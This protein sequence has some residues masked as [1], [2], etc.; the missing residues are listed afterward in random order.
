[1]SKR[2]ALLLTVFAALVLVPLVASAQMAPEPPTYTYVSEW[3]MPRPQW[4]DWIDSNEKNNKPIYEKMMADG[5]IIGYGLYATAVHDESGITHGSWFET[6]SLAA[7][8]KVMSEI[9]KLPPNPIANAATKH[10]DYLI[11][12]SL[13]RVKAASGKDGYLWVNS[14]QLQPGKGAGWRALF[15]KLVKPVFDEQLGNGTLLAYWVEGE[16]VHTDNPDGVFI[17]LLFP[18]AD[19]MDKYFAALQ[20]LI[21]QNPGVGDLLSGVTVGSAHRDYLARVL[22]Y[23]NK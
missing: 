9:A 13:R 14:T 21:A 12:S 1:M 16:Q 17:V 19:A 22:H 8:D 18:S 3:S 6:T 4:K 23:A 15:D 10:R 11:R 5:T 20:K 2:V 7:V